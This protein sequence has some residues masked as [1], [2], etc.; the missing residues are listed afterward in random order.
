M[1]W[2]DL[3]SPRVSVVAIAAATSACPMNNPAFLDSDGAPERTTGEASTTET[4]TT[5]TSGGSAG[6]SSSGGTTTT[7]TT[8]ATTAT[9]STS[10]TTTDASVTVADTGTSEPLTT[11]DT[12]TG[13]TSTGN[14]ACD[15]PTETILKAAA[16]AFFISGG[17][18]NGTTCA[19]YDQITDPTAPCKLLNFGKTGGLRIARLDGG[20][21]A[22]F[23]VRFEHEALAL[24]ADEGEMILDARVVLTL[25]AAIF[26]EDQD[27]RVGK[28]TEEWIEGVKNGEVAGD[29]DSNFD[30]RHVGQA[31]K[32]TNSDGPRGASVEVG[33]LK[34]PLGYANH[35]EVESSPFKIDDWVADP[36]SN[37]GIVI[38]FAKNVMP[39]L[40]GPGIKSRESVEFAPRLIVR[41]CKP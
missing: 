8:T 20:I 40:G 13:D 9:T 22:M 3:I 38:S 23:A 16:D 35:A 31:I 10:T 32:W 15:T 37:N 30:M 6:E 4:G 33:T 27:L 24:L 14:N 36:A 7:T 41:H 34:I 29:G 21:D 2:L 17:T 18:D 11:G 12:S 25:Y 5:T 26:D 28:L 39:D 19:Y 1:R